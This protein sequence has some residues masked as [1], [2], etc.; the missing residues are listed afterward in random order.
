MPGDRAGD[1][2]ALKDT[3]WTPALCLF[4]KDTTGGNGKRMDTSLSDTVNV[5][6]KA[7][8]SN[9][10]L[11][12]NKVRVERQTLGRVESLDSNL[13]KFQSPTPMTPWAYMPRCHRQGA[14]RLLGWGC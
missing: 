14:E 5:A 1:G 3:P 10:R 2:E 13:Q 8:L 7:S 6:W 9:C 4:W 11:R 12:T